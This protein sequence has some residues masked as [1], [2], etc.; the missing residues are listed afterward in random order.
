VLIHDPTLRR[1]TSGRGAVAAFSAAQ[2]ARLDAGG[3]HSPAYAGEPVPRLEDVLAWCR[4]HDVWMNV[5]IKAARRHEAQAGSAVAA[6]CARAFADVL[7]AESERAPQLPLL[8]SFKRA[9][10]LAAQAAVPELPR[11]YLFDRIPAK[12]PAELAALGCVA[13]HCN[14]L[15]LARPLA[16]AIKDAG[17]WLFCYTV[18][19]PARA[20]ELL[21]WGVDALCTDRLDLIGPEFA[22]GAAA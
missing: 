22:A 21:E 18:N 17:Y 15:K 6:A 11:G 7:P 1:T 9:A 19:E 20:Q 13:L 3:W 14:H 4:A 16:R 10:L 8:S 2:L 5:E 12:W